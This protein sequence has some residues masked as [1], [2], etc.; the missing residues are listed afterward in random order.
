VR[1]AFW[2]R[3]VREF[4]SAFSQRRG[5]RLWRAPFFLYADEWKAKL[6]AFTVRLAMQIVGRFSTL[7]DAR[8]F[9]SKRPGLRYKIYED[10]NLIEMTGPPPP[11]TPNLKA[12]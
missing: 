4:R 2:P 11:A 7:E 12:N 3:I 8:P 1:G 5:R 6:V 10:G 9:T